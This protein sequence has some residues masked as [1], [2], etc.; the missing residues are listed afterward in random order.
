MP[1]WDCLPNYEQYHRLLA[2]YTLSVRPQHEL[3][4]AA[5]SESKIFYRS[6]PKFT[7]HSPT[8]STNF[9]DNLQCQPM[10]AS[11]VTDMTM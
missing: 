9:S 7:L 3:R 6:R 10:L 4:M 1:T 8:M 5:R 11:H 2:G